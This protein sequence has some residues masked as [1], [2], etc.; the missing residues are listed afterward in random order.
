MAAYKAQAGAIEAEVVADV[1]V[2][3]KGLA[4]VG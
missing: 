2:F 4:S 3:D 1:P